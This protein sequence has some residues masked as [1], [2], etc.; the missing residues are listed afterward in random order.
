MTDA[1]ASAE[2]SA[3]AA[4]VLRAAVTLARFEHIGSHVAL[5]RRLA[6][7]FPT[8]AASVVDEALRFWASRIVQTEARKRS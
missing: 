5:K 4:D 8:T 3:E 7:E 1:T 2:L 6:K